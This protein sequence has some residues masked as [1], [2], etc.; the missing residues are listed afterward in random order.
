M[1]LMLKMDDIKTDEDL[2]VMQLYY[3]LRAKKSYA[4]ELNNQMMAERMQTE[5]QNMPYMA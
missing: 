3:L 5:I 2:E 4:E 1:A